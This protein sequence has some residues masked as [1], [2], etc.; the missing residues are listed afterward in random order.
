MIMGGFWSFSFQLS[1]PRYCQKR[2]GCRELGFIHK[3]DN[4]VDSILK[5]R[6]L[7]CTL[8]TCLERLRK[9]AY[10]VPLDKLLLKDLLL[11]ISLKGSKAK[12][13]TH[14]PKE[15]VKFFPKHERTEKCSKCSSLFFFKPRHFWTYAVMSVRLWNF[16]GAHCGALAHMP[17]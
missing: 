2:R 6:I 1:N 17:T 14:C 16:K 7:V 12:Q 9:L 5:S 10:I 15:H 11:I 8:S 3:T 4:T 13:A